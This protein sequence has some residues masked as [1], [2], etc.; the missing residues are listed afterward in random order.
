MT[1]DAKAACPL[2]PALLALLQACVD[3]R[4]IRNKTLA[5]RLCLSPDTVHTNFR[6][7]A[8]ALG[9]HDR[10]EAIYIA[11]EHGWIRF[12]TPSPLKPRQQIVHKQVHGNCPDW[13]LATPCSSCYNDAYFHD[14]QASMDI[15]VSR[16]DDAVRAERAV[17][18][19]KK[20]KRLERLINSPV[21]LVVL[22]I[23]TVGL[24]SKWYMLEASFRAPDLAGWSWSAHP[25]TLLIYYP[26]TDCGCGPGLSAALNQAR[27][28][29]FDVALITDVQ[30]RKMDVVTEEVNSSHAHLVSLANTK[31]LN[32]WLRGGNTTMLRIRNGQVVGRAEG[33]V[34]PDSFTKD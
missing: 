8:E 22:A 28:K 34:L 15:P 19:P 14:G 6:R 18:L 11:Y 1:P 30:G 12:P 7:I 9:T 3:A 4:C 33:T 13:G 31:S 26:N 21:L 27:H 16:V 25:N 17:A 10:F 32:H 24:G 2:S 20:K 23:A 29:H 5:D